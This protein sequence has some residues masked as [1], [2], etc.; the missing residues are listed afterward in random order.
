MRLQTKGQSVCAGKGGSHGDV[1]MMEHAISMLKAQGHSGDKDTIMMIG[2][3]FDTDIRGG[4]S[5][6]IKTC[7]VQSG[8]HQ[9]R[10]QS[11]FPDDMA[12]WTSPSVAYLVPKDERAGASAAAAASMPA[13]PPGWQSLKEKTSFGLMSAWDE[14]AARSTT[15]ARKSSK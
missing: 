8:A 4:I 13:T 9:A 1:F 2:D 6:G 11:R 12:S 7:L 10:Q 3:R 15:L 5:A 14:D